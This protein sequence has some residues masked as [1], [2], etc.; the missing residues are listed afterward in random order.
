MPQGL[1]D[2]V[3]GSRHFGSIKNVYPLCNRYQVGRL[4]HPNCKREKEFLDPG[5][6]FS[7]LRR[8]FNSARRNQDSRTTA[9]IAVSFSEGAN[10]DVQGTSK[11][12]FSGFENFSCCC[13]PLLSQLAC[14]ILA[15]WERP[16]SPALHLRVLSNH[17]DLTCR[18]APSP[19][20]PGRRGELST[21]QSTAPSAFA[22]AS[23][24]GSAACFPV[25][26]KKISMRHL[27]R[28]C[29]SLARF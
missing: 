25:V 17:Y 5:P 6:G 4:P 3:G 18:V 7:H 16:Y 20:S 19:P 2:S 12:P 15:T 9:V 8:Q 11:R 24:L 28:G 23:T 26:R 29:H 21:A 13:L 14:C 10:A 27:M 1:D 22:R